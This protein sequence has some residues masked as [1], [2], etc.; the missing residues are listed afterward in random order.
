MAFH[1][2]IRFRR[3]RKRI[4]RDF[5]LPLTS[6]LDV[7]VIILVF[8]LKSYA[9][10]PNSFTTVPGLKL[11]LSGSPEVPPDSL[12]VIITPEGM[13]FENERVVEFVVSAVNAGVADDT[14]A[15]AFKKG[16][17]DE[18]G[19]RI[20]PLFDALV[21]A[22]EKAELLRAKSKAR[23]EQGNPLPFDGVLAIQADK[24]VKYDTIRKIMYTAATAGYRTFRFLATA[25]ES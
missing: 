23:D 8:L 5:E 22:R 2:S 24:R 3:N 18:G 25:R 10:S 7:L 15:Y 6:M 14:A 9:T 21:K 1:R 13:T 19:R 11:P 4:H 16:D 12:Q 20:V 17:L